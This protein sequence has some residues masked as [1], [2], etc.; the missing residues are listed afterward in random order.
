MIRGVLT[1]LVV[2]VQFF[3][4]ELLTH[5][6]IRPWIRL[7][8]ASRD[9]VLNAWGRYLSGRT[10]WPLRLVGGARFDLRGRI[11]AREGVL[12]LANH[13][14]L[15]DIPIA[16]KTLEGTYP[17]IV[18]RA[19][20]AKGIPVISGVCELFDYPLVEP[21]RMSAEDIRALARHAAEGVKPVVVYPEGHRTRDGRILPFKKAG[22]SAILSER[23]WVVY[24]LVV[25]GLW[26]CAK[27]KDFIRGV[28]TIRA[29][30]EVIGPFPA[31]ESTEL[32]GP[33]L[34]EVRERMTAKLEE[35]RGDSARS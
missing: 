22:V 1:L 27:L 10:F 9:R 28:G 32:V 18:T 20:Y 6:V 5:L 16:F 15:M 29:R 13:Q 23:P 25:D 12:V 19:R 31:P 2:A 30:S 26:S 35:M 14:S 11:P 24:V 7:R 4:A 17:R 33:F 21:G 34:D 3:W 8:P